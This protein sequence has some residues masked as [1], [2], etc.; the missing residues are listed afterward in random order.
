MLVAALN[1]LPWFGA[2]AF[3]QLVQVVQTPFN[4]NTQAASL[5]GS[6][7]S[8]KLSSHIRDLLN[9]ASVPGYAIAIVRP[10]HDIDVEVE[11]GNWGNKTEDGD[12]VTPDVSPS[13]SISTRTFDKC[14]MKDPLYPRVRLQGFHCDR[15]RPANRRLCQRPQRDCATNR[16]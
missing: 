5:G 16:C 11:Y 3:A 7:L 13:S 14:C 15:I 4:V 10:G 6:I 12:R 9:N 2:S 1:F 8:P